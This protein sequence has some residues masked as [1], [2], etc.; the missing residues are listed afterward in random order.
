MKIEPFGN[1]IAIARSTT[2]MAGRS[3]IRHHKGMLFMAS[4]LLILGGH[5]Q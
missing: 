3:M 4:T 2:K 5:K 1:N